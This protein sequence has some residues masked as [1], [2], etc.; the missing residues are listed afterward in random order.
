MSK[1]TFILVTLISALSITLVVYSI[2]K[3]DPPIHRSDVV[4]NAGEGVDAIILNV[5]NIK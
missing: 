5:P 2:I 1:K 3:S 4:V